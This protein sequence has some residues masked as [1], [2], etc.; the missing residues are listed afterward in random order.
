MEIQGK[1]IR[2]AKVLRQI[3][4]VTKVG[5]GAEEVEDPRNQWGLSKL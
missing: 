3:R 4:I 5:L 2:Q 1:L